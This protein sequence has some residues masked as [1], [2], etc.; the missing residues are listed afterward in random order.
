MAKRRSKGTFHHANLKNGQGVRGGVAYRA[1]SESKA[2]DREYPR[3]LYVAVNA[4]LA[5]FALAILAGLLLVFTPLGEMWNRDKGQ[6][7]EI[8]Y[9]IEFYDVNGDLGAAPVEG[10]HLFDAV[11]GRDLGEAIGIT[12]SPYVLPPEMLREQADNEAADSATTGNAQIVSMTVSVNA[13]YEDGIGYTVYGIRIAKGLSYTVSF[14]GSV[15]S[16]NCVSVEK[17]W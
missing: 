17:R 6:A 3:S 9:T 1:L 2:G 8:L 11:T 10:T 5:L 13:H 15:A 4:V 16:G 7:Q 14:S 12:V